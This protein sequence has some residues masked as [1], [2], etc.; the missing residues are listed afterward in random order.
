MHILF[1]LLD[2]PLQLHQRSC[3]FAWSFLSAV[4]ERMV[5][6]VDARHG[7]DFIH[8]WVPPLNVLNNCLA[9]VFDLNP[10]VVVQIRYHK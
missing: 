1:L 9:V 8:V 2:C 6:S 3:S 10:L 5:R 4:D 7:C